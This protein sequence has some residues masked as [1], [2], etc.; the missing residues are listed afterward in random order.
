MFHHSIL[1]KFL[2]LSFCHLFFSSI[3]LWALPFDIITISYFDKFVNRENENN[4]KFFHRPQNH[5][6]SHQ[7]LHLI[8]LYK[9]SSK[10]QVGLCRP[11]I[12]FY[13][14]STFLIL[15][16][17]SSFMII[18][19]NGFPSPPSPS[20]SSI[21]PFFERLPNTPRAAPLLSPHP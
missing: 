21:N 5:E 19:V 2:I 12:Y 4:S 13:Q 9:Q 8:L 6:D 17:S 3:E 15:L 18:H 1:S 11:T 7:T 20:A 16:N 14:P 10:Q